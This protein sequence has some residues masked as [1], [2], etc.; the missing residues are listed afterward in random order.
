MSAGVRVER[1][2]VGRGGLKKKKGGGRKG[3][4]DLNREKRGGG[5]RGCFGNDWPWRA[6]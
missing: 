2:G 6:K 3:R 4:K 1:F 5:G